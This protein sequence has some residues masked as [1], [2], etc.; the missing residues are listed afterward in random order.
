MKRLARFRFA[1]V[2]LAMPLLA[3]CKE[4]TLVGSY[5][6]TT[7]T[8]AQAGGPSK[9]VLAAGGSIHL[10][11]AHDYSTSGS[12]QIP[13]SVTAASAYSASLLGTAAQNGSSVTLNLVAD[14]F[15]RDMTFTFNGE[16][17]TGTG[18]FSGTTVVVTL[19]K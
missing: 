13:A 14:T 18:T 17:L 1:W 16:S 11:I 4:D 6:A 7:F 2:A 10:S 9:D 12:I 19:S 3:S 8:Y 15:L 5:A